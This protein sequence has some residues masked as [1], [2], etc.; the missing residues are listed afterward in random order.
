VLKK[1]RFLCNLTGVQKIA[2][3]NVYCAGV[4]LWS[5][6]KIQEMSKGHKISGAFTLFFSL[7]YNFVNIFQKNRDI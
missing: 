3:E 6:E 7:D 1:G 2:S 4:N 5:Q